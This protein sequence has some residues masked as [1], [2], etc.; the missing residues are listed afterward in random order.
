[1]GKY[2]LGRCRQAVPVLFGVTLITFLLTHVALGDPVRAMMG[3]R[4]D[5]DIVA[6]IRVEYGLDEPVWKRYVRYLG[7]LVVG[8][9]GTSYRQGRP[10]SE[11]I[12]ERLPATARLAVAAM[13]IALVLG[14]AAGVVA[15]MRH[16]TLVDLLLMMGA[17]L[18]ISTPVFWLGM[19]LIILFGVWLGWFPISGYGEGDI[20]HLILPALTLGVLQAGI[21]ARITRSALLEVL[22]QEY[23]RTARAKGLREGVVVLKHGLRNG[24]MPVITLA[25]IGLGDLLVGAP[26]TETVFAWPGLGRLLVSAVGN[27]DL[28]VVVGATF[29]FAL[30]YLGASLLVDLAYALV[31]PRIRVVE[32]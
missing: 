11:V 23:I 30:I 2:L 28:P 8:D 25:G 12:A 15:A 32:Q 20:R 18:G 10:V 31:D 4:A 13:G 27:R 9:L 7:K 3:Q 26:L 6:R 16:N 21:I 5:P 19:M 29:V 14:V 22:H 24:L 17:L 1:M